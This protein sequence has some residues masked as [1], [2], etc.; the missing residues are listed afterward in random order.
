MANKVLILG[1]SFSMG[2]YGTLDDKTDQVLS[3]YCWYHELSKDYDYD[4]YT[5]ASGGYLN[6]AALLQK[7][8]L[9]QYHAIII[10]QTLDP[11][12]LVLNEPEYICY[13]RN[14]NIKVYKPLKN[15]K[16]YRKGMYNQEKTNWQE[17]YKIKISPE[18]QFFFDDFDSSHTIGLIANAMYDYVDDLCKQSGKPA[19][20]FSMNQWY[21]KAPIHKYIKGLNDE[22]R[23][24][25]WRNPKYQVNPPLGHFNEEG[26]KLIGKDLCQQIT[27]LI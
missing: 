2:S 4:V 15:M 21:Y 1:C 26:N 20:A 6:Y 12:F 10:Q 24:V 8:D 11:R 18:L 25:I 14:N 27:S 19:L 17:K 23:K 13:H 9:D 16:V 5:T 7:L 22:F 3:N